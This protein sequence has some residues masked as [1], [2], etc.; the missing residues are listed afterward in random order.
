MSFVTQYVK[1]LYSECLHDDWFTLSCDIAA[2]NQEVAE[3]KL[4]ALADMEFIPMKGCSI[5]SFYLTMMMA[6]SM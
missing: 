6:S 3:E 2:N 4:D 5:A 1:E